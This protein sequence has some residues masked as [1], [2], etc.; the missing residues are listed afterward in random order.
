MESRGRV[1]SFFI[2]APRPI[3]WEDTGDL[4]KIWKLYVALRPDFLV[5]GGTIMNIVDLSKDPPIIRPDVIVECKE[6]EDWY[7][8]TRDLRGWFSKAMSAE[9]WRL[10]WLKGLWE[11]L[12]EAMGIRPKEEYK[13]LSTE[14]KSLRLKEYKLIQI[15]KKFYK[16]KSMI[17]VTRTSLP[18]EI[19]R[20]IEESGLTVYDNIGFNDG[21]LHEVTYELLKYGKK[22]NRND[23]LEILG[24]IVGN[25]IFNIEQNILLDSII[26]LINKH[27]DEF[28]EIVKRR[29]IH[30]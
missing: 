22:E 28:M 12:A 25:Q 29:S 23:L 30:N 18:D 24:K 8:R 13:K 2:E 14:K 9:E 21:K 19:K 5:Y 1:L 26:E 16:P 10:L 17:L 3:A 7:K 11:G 27:K 15:Y 6:L 20:E 4:R